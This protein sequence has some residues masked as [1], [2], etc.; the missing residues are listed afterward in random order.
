MIF[1]VVEHIK[2]S[3][4]NYRGRSPWLDRVAVFILNSGLLCFVDCREAYVCHV[5][6]FVRVLRIAFVL[7]CMMCGVCRAQI[8]ILHIITQIFLE[9]I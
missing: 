1:S 6:V 9:S 4:L 8:L 7:L 2:N 3:N 5:C